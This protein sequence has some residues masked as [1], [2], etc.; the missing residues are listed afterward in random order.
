[1]EAGTFVCLFVILKVPIHYHLR[2]SLLGDS[3]TLWTP[4]QYG[5]QSFVIGDF[6]SPVYNG[7]VSAGLVTIILLPVILTFYPS[8]ALC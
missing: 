5:T 3:P 7:A 1:M 2:K 6:S 8:V 4:F